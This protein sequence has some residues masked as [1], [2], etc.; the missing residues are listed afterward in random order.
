MVS[1][2]LSILLRNS[3]ILKNT[4]SWAMFIPGIERNS[5]KTLAAK[6]LDVFD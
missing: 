2:L 6:Y 3:G 1:I 5:S 4:E